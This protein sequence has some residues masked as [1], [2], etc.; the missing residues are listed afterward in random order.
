MPLPFAL[1]FGFALGV[2]L[3]QVAKA[4]LARGDGPLATSR[5][6]AVVGAFAAIVYVPIVAYSAAF[7]GDWAYLYVVP[8]RAV[9]SAVDLALVLAAGGAVVVGFVSAV[10]PVRT[11]ST[12]TLATMV[13]VPGAALLLLLA[14]SA[15][16][17]AVSASYVQFHG[18]FGVE[19]ITSSAL[20]RSVLWSVLALT[21][22]VAWAVRA[23]RSGR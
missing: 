23:I 17:L 15:R 14:A 1:L 4:E 20:G 10:P 11:R 7:H 8:W 16:R 6:L 12:R 2:L 19:P 9:P 18:A 22:G 13:G 3:A 5:A 21:A